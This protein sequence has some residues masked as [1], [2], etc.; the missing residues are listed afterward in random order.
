MCTY[1]VLLVMLHEASG[2]EITS[3]LGALGSAPV[4][5]PL[6]HGQRS[7]CLILV[8]NKQNKTDGDKAGG[9]RE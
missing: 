1:S 6:D 9:F 3:W 8:L 2:V 4:T 5:P 7:P